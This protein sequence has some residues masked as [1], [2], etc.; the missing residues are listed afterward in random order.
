[1][2]EVQAVE[3]QQPVVMDN[4]EQVYNKNIDDLMDYINK[5]QPK[6][7]GKKNKKKPKKKKNDP[8]TAVEEGAEI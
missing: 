1:M 7:G 5:A 3:P 8:E 2:A 4:G 6:E